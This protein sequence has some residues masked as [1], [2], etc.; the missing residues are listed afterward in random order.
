V[1]LSP[2]TD[3]KATKRCGWEGNSR[4]DVALVIRHSFKWFIHMWAKWLQESAQTPR[5]HSCEDCGTLYFTFM[6][7]RSGVATLRT[8]IHLLLTYLRHTLLLW[9]PFSKSATDSTSS[10]AY[11]T[12]ELLSPTKPS[13][14]YT[15]PCRSSGAITDRKHSRH[16]VARVRNE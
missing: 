12:G 8:A 14:V 11:T 2:N 5:L 15:L 3:Q 13:N 9:A 7:S 10:V 4:S 1:P 6:S 16:A